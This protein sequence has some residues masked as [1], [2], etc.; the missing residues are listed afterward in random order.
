MKK[1]FK[2]HAFMCGIIS[3][4]G[5]MFLTG[6]FPT[7]SLSAE[8]KVFN[9]KFSSHTTP[10]SK[11]LAPCQLWWA[12]QIE[13]RSKG[14]IKIKMYWVDELCGPKEMM[15][16][17]KSRL[18]D[19]VG[20]VPGYTPG[21]TPIWNSTYLPFLWA[22][23]VDQTM[24]IYDRLAKE[25]RPFID[26]MNRFNCVYAGAYE[27]GGYNM[28]GKKPVRTVNDFK[29]LRIRVMTDLGEIIKQFGAVTMLV[30]V[31]EMYSAL[32]TGIV[33]IVTHDR[34]AFHAYKIDEI[35]KYLMIDMNMGAAPTFY[36]INKDAW[37]ELPDHLKKVVQSVIDDSA[38]FMWD[39]HRRPDRIAE[40]EKTIK[41]RNIE[42]IQFPSAERAK[43]EAKAEAV[44]DAWAKRTANYENAKMALSDYV[45][46]RN[47]VISKYPQGAPGIQYK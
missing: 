47:E 12:E 22:P 7:D 4:F 8:K 32:D 26:E 33:D 16:A 5:I 25:S 36:F 11:S 3:L 37:N 23:R 15:M 41:E 39:Y 38:A 19:V 18:A 35:S 10:G 14:E 42:V 28:M 17:V 1:S 9:W 24:L 31:T 29:G 21:E 30:P 20:H 2:I 27:H 44:W 46:I 45:K 40:A 43:I 34:L 6:I 13:K